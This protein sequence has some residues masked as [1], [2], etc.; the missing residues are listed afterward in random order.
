M[1]GIGND[2]S[3]KYYTKLTHLLCGVTFNNYTKA[4][5][6]YGIE[7]WIDCFVVFSKGTM[8][9][10]HKIEENNLFNCIRY[11]LILFFIAS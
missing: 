4:R 3:D 2:K 7:I 11:N 8:R 1:P 9:A 6:Y 10:P 5:G